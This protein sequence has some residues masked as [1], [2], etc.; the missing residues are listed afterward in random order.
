MP[1]PPA[2]DT[3][4][5]ERIGTR[6]TP[7]E[8]LQADATAAVLGIPL[9]ALIRQLLRKEAARLARKQERGRR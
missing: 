9:G 8:K 7:S 1:R 5:T 4:A 2:G 6:V 3:A